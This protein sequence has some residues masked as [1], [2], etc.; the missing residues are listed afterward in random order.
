MTVL[1]YFWINKVGLGEYNA[2]RFIYLF[3]LLTTFIATELQILCHC[4]ERFLF[5]SCALRWTQVFYTQ[6]GFQSAC[7]FI[8]LRLTTCWEERYWLPWS[9]ESDNAEALAP[10]PRFTAGAI[11]SLSP[12][13]HVKTLL[14]PAALTTNAS[15][16]KAL[17]LLLGHFIYPV[18]CKILNFLWIPVLL[19]CLEL[20]TFIT[21]V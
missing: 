16:P 5:V 9:P 2:I 11:N 15:F 7:I 4:I 20:L 1:L 12:C 13:H 10:G 8:S 21:T 14:C 6:R 18:S 17:W 3:C 19:Y